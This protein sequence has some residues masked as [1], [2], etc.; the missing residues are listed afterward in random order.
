[1]STSLCGYPQVLASS[2]SDENKMLKLKLKSP[3]KTPGEFSLRQSPRDSGECK[4]YL[5]ERV[6][7]KR[8]NE[9]NGG[10]CTSLPSCTCSCPFA[11]VFFMFVLGGMLV[12]SR[13]MHICAHLYL[14]ALALFIFVLV[15]HV[16]V[17]TGC[18][19][20]RSLALVC[21]GSTVRRCAR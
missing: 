6:P 17:V 20:S 15:E 9:R 16:C 5:T 21:L 12:L 11:R 8:K 18:A 4:W 1:V 13:V 2:T 7:R 10:D 14:F 19:Y 3:K